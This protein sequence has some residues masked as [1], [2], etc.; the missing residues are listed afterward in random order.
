[1]KLIGDTSISELYMAVD[2]VLNENDELEKS[3]RSN[4]INSEKTEAQKGTP[5]HH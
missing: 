4:R 3:Q 2:V 5:C 1:M